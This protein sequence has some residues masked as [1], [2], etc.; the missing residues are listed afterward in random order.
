MNTGEVFHNGFFPQGRTVFIAD[1]FWRD[2]KNF[3]KDFR[4]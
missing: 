3:E 4:N 1:F 2:F